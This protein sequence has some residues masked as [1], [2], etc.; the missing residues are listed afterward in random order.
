MGPKETRLAAGLSQDV[1]GVLAGTTSPTIRLFETDP[2]N[3][4]KNTSKRAA[5][6]RVYAELAVK[7][8]ARTAPRP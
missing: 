1:V 8:A 3:G 6:A 2:V 7:V 4:V 5:I